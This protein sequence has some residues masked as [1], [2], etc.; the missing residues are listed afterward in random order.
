M[1]IGWG[2]VAVIGL[3]AGFTLGEEY[4][5]EMRRRRRRRGR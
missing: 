1:L 3:I 4:E 5:R 2:L